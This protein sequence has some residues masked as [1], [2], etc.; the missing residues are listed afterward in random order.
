MAYDPP[1]ASEVKARFEEFEDVS[2]PKIDLLIA[3]A[4]RVVDTT[5]LEADYT[6]AIKYWVAHTLALEK[7]SMSVNGE[8]FVT[9]LIKSESLGDASISYDT[10]GAGTKGGASDYMATSYG[11]RFLTLLRA[12]APGVVVI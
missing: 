5:W 12:N 1:T 6:V 8:G 3:E 11:R 4:Q 2:D 10:G 9:G 7:S